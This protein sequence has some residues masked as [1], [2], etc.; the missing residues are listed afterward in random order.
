[1]NSFADVFRLIWIIYLFRYKNL[2]YEMKQ[3]IYYSN[4]VT[5]PSNTYTFIHFH[6]DNVIVLIFTP[7]FP[8]NKNIWIVAFKTYW[9]MKLSCKNIIVH[10]ITTRDIFNFK[11]LFM[12]EHC[13]YIY[14]LFLDTCFDDWLF[15]KLLLNI[16]WFSFCFCFIYFSWISFSKFC[17]MEDTIST[18][19]NHLH[20]H[21]WI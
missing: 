21:L 5:S 1:M 18:Y 16:L 3:H 7:N 10:Q 17:L 13:I 2:A 19:T 12:Y 11:Y 9:D 14:V 20:L 4:K 15:C 8:E 6:C